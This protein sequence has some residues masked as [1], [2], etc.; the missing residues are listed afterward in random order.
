MRKLWLALGLVLFAQA[1]LA[2]EPPSAI[3]GHTGNDLKALLDSRDGFEHGLAYGYIEAT[4]DLA[5]DLKMICTPPRVTYGQMLDIV[6][7]FLNDHPER[8]HERKPDL[9]LDALI[10]AFPCKRGG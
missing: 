4:S 3:T 7:K 6:G 1:A 10:A 8:R 2:D 5:R 9:V